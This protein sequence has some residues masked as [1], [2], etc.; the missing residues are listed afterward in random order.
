MFG[1]ASDEPSHGAG[2]SLRSTQIFGGTPHPGAGAEDPRAAATD[3]GSAEGG[4]SLRSTQ[5]F[6]AGAVA[7]AESGPHKPIPTKTQ[8]FGAT[9]GRGFTQTFAVPTGN[10]GAPPPT[11]EP[12]PE[13]R[14]EPTRSPAVAAVR[15]APVE[16]PPDE[17][18]GS[19]SEERTLP[20]DSIHLQAQLQR[21]NRTA[22][23]VV[24]LLALG[25]ITFVGVRAFLGRSRAV[26][27]AW[28]AAREQALSLLRRDDAGSRRQA[29]E[30][31][32]QLV[33]EHPAF[34]EARADHLLALALA[35]DDAS[36][37]RSRIQAASA[38]LNRR[39]KRLQ[40]AQSPSD[41]ANRAN[42]LR[43]E[44]I[45][46][47][48]KDAPL[49]K[50]LDGLRAEVAAAVAALSRASQKLTPAEQLS[51]MRAEAVYSGVAGKDEAL[52][53]SK[54]YELQ[55]PPDGW[56]QIAYAEYALNTKSP[57][58]TLRQAREQME[59]LR[60]SDRGFLR[61][62]VLSARLALALKQYD[63]ASSA[64]EA[65]KTM[66][67]SHAVAAELLEWVQESS[68]GDAR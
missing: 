16:L 51:V 11:E 56:G 32:G 40:D 10:D 13:P 27:E 17:F 20:D 60:E 7:A 47:D 29:L 44:L 28:T 63:E 49:G 8:V 19:A 3:P 59:A 46:L 6:G 61:P 14:P 18:G 2:E 4:A 12:K 68:R 30:Q 64:L 42:A 50:E 15:R 34:T 23:M 26:P 41:W 45:A 35:L 37:A 62:Y 25:I 36:I 66:N 21:R 58:E 39:I 57:P 1:A 9:S 52:G 48:K 43:E 38:E 5:I 31:L 24:G 65:V 55:G 22:L 33:K 67:A 53:R 54:A